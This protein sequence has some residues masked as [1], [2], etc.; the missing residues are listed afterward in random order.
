MRN[1]V[2]NLYSM[3]LISDIRDWCFV[4]AGVPS[5]TLSGIPLVTME[6]M[7]AM[8]PLQYASAVQAPTLVLLGEKDLRV[9]PEQVCLGGC[10]T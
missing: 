9:P 2:I 6:R 7:A 8:S 3:V 5:A 10:W 4:E 1:P